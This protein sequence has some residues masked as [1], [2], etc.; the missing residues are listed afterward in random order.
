MILKN[1]SFKVQVD[2]TKSPALLDAL[3]EVLLDDRFNLRAGQFLVPFSLESTTSAGRLLT[4]N[5][6]RVV[7]LLAP[8]RDNNSAGRDLGL[9]V[10]GRFSIFQ[11]TLGLVNG[12]GI[13]K[14]DDNGHKD[15][16]GRLIAS[17]AGAETW[18][19]SSNGGVDAPSQTTSQNRLA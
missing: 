1:L 3:A 9:V 10:F 4:I 18:R 6:S 19:S 15:F 14:K 7:D 8:G 5:R 12:T 13:N 2:L 17:R 11:Y 16:A